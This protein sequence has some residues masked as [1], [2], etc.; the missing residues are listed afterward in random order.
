MG[1]KKYFNFF[2]WRV[3][4]LRGMEYK[5]ICINLLLYPIA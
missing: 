3:K 2:G 4:N 5:I 1:D